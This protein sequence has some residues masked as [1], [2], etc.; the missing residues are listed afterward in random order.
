MTS[1]PMLNP[2]TTSFARPTRSLRARWMQSMAA[3]ALSVI[4]AVRSS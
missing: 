4:E 1:P 2:P 3:S